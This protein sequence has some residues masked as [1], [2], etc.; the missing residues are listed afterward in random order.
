[1]PLEPH[2]KKLGVLVVVIWDHV[3]NT[4]SC[5]LWTEH[6][7]SSHFIKPFSY[8]AFPMLWFFMEPPAEI[9]WQHKASEETSSQ[10]EE[11]APAPTLLRSET[12][13]RATLL[14]VCASWCTAGR[15][16][17][18]PGGQENGEAAKKGHPKLSSEKVYHRAPQLV[19]SD[20]VFPLC[21]CADLDQGSKYHAPFHLR[22]QA[23][24][25]CH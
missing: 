25:I 17:L 1:M 19:C 12:L 2:E 7:Y 4:C 24:Q 21:L 8:V 13:S 9:R 18:A 11:P 20:W 3:G 22:T 15:S 5:T 16:W 6:P 23:C 14:P 10:N